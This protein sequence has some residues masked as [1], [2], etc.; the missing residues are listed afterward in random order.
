[1]VDL[2]LLRTYCD[3]VCEMERMSGMYVCVCV[4]VCACVC[5][6]VG[7]RVSERESACKRE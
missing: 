7:E 2:S 6:N 3:R 5:A 1:M 4:C